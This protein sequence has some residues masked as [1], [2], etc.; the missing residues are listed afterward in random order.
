MSADRT[1]LARQLNVR[2]VSLEPLIKAGFIKVLRT[3]R[4]RKRTEPVPQSRE[5]KNPPI[6]P[7]GGTEKRERP[8]ERRAREEA[9]WKRAKAVQTCRRLYEAA[10]DDGEQPAVI[11][12]SLECEYNHDKAIVFE[13]IASSEAKAKIQ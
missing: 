12:D 2:R 13:A 7:K 8:R 6:P 3:K 4:V 1:L 10:L 9:E 5:E 11:R